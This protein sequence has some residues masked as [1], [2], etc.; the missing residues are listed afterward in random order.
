[1]LVIERHHPVVEELGRG[2]RRLAIIEL[3]EGELGIGVDEGLRGCQVFCVRG[4]RETLYLVEGIT[5]YGTG[6]QGRAD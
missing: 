3:G 1:M 4:S 6:N 5:D 2:A